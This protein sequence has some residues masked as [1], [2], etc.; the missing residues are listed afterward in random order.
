M[1]LKWFHSSPAVQPLVKLRGTK[2]VTE[3]NIKIISNETVN[4]DG[5]VKTSIVASSSIRMMIATRCIPT[6]FVKTGVTEKIC[7]VYLV[8]IIILLATIL[9]CVLFVPPSLLI[10]SFEIL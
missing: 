10:V 1:L 6:V 2:K 9:V 3:T 8:A 7:R 5:C 4:R